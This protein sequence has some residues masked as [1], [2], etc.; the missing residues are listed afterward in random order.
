LRFAAATPVS[1]SP[2]PISDEKQK[3]S[4]LM[5]ENVGSSVSCGV[6]ITSGRGEQNAALYTIMYRMTRLGYLCYLC[7][8]SIISTLHILHIAA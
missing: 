1:A 2:K 4:N 5:H 8:L 3:L 6:G 7:C